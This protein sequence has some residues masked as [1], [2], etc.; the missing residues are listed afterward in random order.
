MPFTDGSRFLMK[1]SST[2]FQPL[3]TNPSVGMLVLV[4]VLC[5]SKNVWRLFISG[6][7]SGNRCISK[8]SQKLMRTW[9]ATI[10]TTSDNTSVIQT[11]IAGL[12]KPLVTFS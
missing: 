6:G 9:N 3:F 8:T 10:L 11:V 7:K 5:V 4:G 2:Y 1:I 12:E